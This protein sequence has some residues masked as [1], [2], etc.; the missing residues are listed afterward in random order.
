MLSG[1]RMRGAGARSCAS[2]AWAWHAVPAGPGFERGRSRPG[3]LRGVASSL[4]LPGLRHGDVGRARGHGLPLPLPGARG[5]GGDGAVVRRRV[6]RGGPTTSEPR[7]RGGCDGAA[8][9]ELASSMGARRRTRRAVAEHSPPH[10]LDTPRRRP[11]CHFDLGGS[12]TAGRDRAH[13]D[14]RGRDTSSVRACP[15]AS[16][17]KRAPPARVP[18]RIETARAA[19]VGARMDERHEGE[20]HE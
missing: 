14:L 2:S 12:R 18:P 1:M 3:T 11:P 9:V 10:G 4:P 13:A 6:A 19:S 17:A 5:G 15:Y 20:A 16:G 8:S 7:R